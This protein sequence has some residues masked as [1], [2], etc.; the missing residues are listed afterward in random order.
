MKIPVGIPVFVAA[1]GTDPRFARLVHRWLFSSVFWLLLG[2]AV[3]LIEAYR[4]VDPEFLGNS[5]LITYGRLRPFHTMGMLFGWCSMALLALALYVVPKCSRI[6]MDETELRASNAALWL[7]NAGVLGG[8]VALLLGQLNGGR[9]YREYPLWAMALIASGVVTLG[10]VFYRMIARRQTKGIYISCWFILAACSW[11]AVVVVMGYLPMFRRGLADT[12]VQG[13]YMHN[14]VGMWFTP[15]V[16]GLTYYALPKL[17][18][19]PIY[20]YALGVLGI[21]THLL[22]YTLIGTHHYM[23]SAMPD[24]LENMALIFSVAMLV[25]VF[26]SAGNFLLTMKG[27]KVAI[28]QSYSLPFLLVGVIGYI[29]ASAQGSFQALREVQDSLHLTHYTVG[30]SHVAMYFFVSFLL[31]GL[32][33]GLVP[34][35]TGREPPVG[36][37]GIHFW[38]A[39]AGGTIMVLALCLGGAEQGATGVEGKPFMD[40]VR[41][42]KPYMV[43]RVV[44]GCLMA[45]SHLLSAVAIYAMRPGALLDIFG[46]PSTQ[47][48]Q[49]PSAPQAPEGRA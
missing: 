25:P 26:A 11:V 32:I 30:H 10:W 18:N 21:F 31:W 5:A 49:P 3:G 37:V 19:K 1:A 35:I 7:W 42:V 41:V 14:A 15:L 6:T 44:G 16:V 40:G 38:L 20:S 22:F 39:F 28:Q 43:W 48:P 13:F 45:A 9:E 36:L 29:L 17:L 23:F 2:S 12:I 27:E 33:Y 46:T 34:R 24:W 47:P 8:S 4:H